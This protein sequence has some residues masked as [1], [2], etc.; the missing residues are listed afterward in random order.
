MTTAI[1]GTDSPQP[2]VLRG[3]EMRTPDEVAAM[4]RLW[5]L[6][7]GTPRLADTARLRVRGM[8][9]RCRFWGREDPVGRRLW[10]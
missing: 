9:Y 1:S 5:A 10:G 3:D 4:L 8:C 2:G 7:G 6:G